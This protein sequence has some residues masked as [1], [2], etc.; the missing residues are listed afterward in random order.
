MTINEKDKLINSFLIS[1]IF[2]FTILIF[3][4]IMIYSNN[5]YEFSYTLFHIFIFFLIL[6]IFLVLLLN[7]LFYFL[8]DK[9]LYIFFI[10]TLLLVI[11]S[12]FMV[13]NYGELDGSIIKW[14]KYIYYGVIDTMVWILLLIVAIKKKDI[15]LKNIK[16]ITIGLISFEI[17]LLILTIFLNKIVEQEKKIWFKTIELT[18]NI[19]FSKN[20]NVIVWIL[21]ATESEVF[22]EIINEREEYNTYFK[23]FTFYRDYLAGASSTNCAIAPLLTTK[24]F[25]N[26]QPK[27]DFYN[28][29]YYHPNYSILKIL[30]N[31][32]YDINIDMTKGILSYESYSIDKNIVSNYGNKNKKILSQKNIKS[33]LYV[34]DISLMRTLPYFLKRFIYN[35]GELFLFKYLE[36]IYLSCIYIYEKINMKKD[37]NNNEKQE[38]N[39]QNN[40][41]SNKIEHSNYVI[42]SETPVNDILD[43]FMKSKF[44]PKDFD[45]LLTKDIIKNSF[46]TDKNVFNLIHLNGAH[47]AFDFDEFGN[48][49][50]NMRED[51]EAYKGKY[52]HSLKITKSFLDYL[53]VKNIYDDSLII[54]L[55]DHGISSEIIGNK[56]PMLWQKVRS[57]P[58]FMIKEINKTNDSLKISNSEISA[59]DVEKTIIELVGIDSTNISGENVLKVEEDRIKERMF[60]Y[61]RWVWGGKER[62]FYLPTIYEYNVLGN[63]RDDAS[64]SF[65][66]KIFIKNKIIDFLANESIDND[67]FKRE[68]LSKI[69]NDD[70]KNFI[71]NLYKDTKDGFILKEIDDENKN[72][73]IDILTK[74]F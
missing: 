29:V 10:I 63:V 46:F 23:D 54:I 25:L 72:R 12:N 34:V 65:S 44:H 58:L 59:F 69:K 36:K 60:Y 49:I 38:I 51:R 47:S 42:K 37:K 39:I 5:V 6:M 26:Q 4:V 35:N 19:S 57:N 68:L 40:I 2:S 50:L 22:E 67:I 71:L 74:T 11:Q 17:I 30:K 1:F 27:M 66:G 43:S 32:G 7:L 3:N 52:I 14:G 31:N 61:H 41:D 20:Q 16:I 45:A 73:L 9:I 8:S 15:L 13:W 48:Y 70:D 21:D 56:N 24:I 18:E 64:W 62:V 55:G 33:Y 28:E 53:K